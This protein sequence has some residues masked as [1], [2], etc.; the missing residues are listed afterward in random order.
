M[1]EEN[2]IEKMVCQLVEKLDRK[3]SK[4]TDKALKIPEDVSD[5]LVAD[6]EIF[7]YI[8]L[9]SELELILEIYN[10]SEGAK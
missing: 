10:Q 7:V 3:I 1:G 2:E 5:R 9:K 8:E 6:S 4:L